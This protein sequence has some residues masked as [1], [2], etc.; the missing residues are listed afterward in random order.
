MAAPL[1]LGRIWLGKNAKKWL[2]PLC[3]HSIKPIPFHGGEEI[4]RLHGALICGA[5]QPSGVPIRES[6]HAAEV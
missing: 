2:Q 6:Q 1:L 3:F 5:Y 4:H